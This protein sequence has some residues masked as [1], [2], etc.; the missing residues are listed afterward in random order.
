MTKT[1]KI[2]AALFL[3]AGSVRGAETKTFNIRDFG[4]K[5][6]GKT[7]D[8]A[9]IQKAIDT[10]SA[11]GGGMVLIPEGK[12]VTMPFTLASDIN[13]HLAAGAEILISDDMA[14]YPAEKNRYVDAITAKHAH[15][16][17]ISGTGTINGQGEAWWK[18]FRENPKM[19]HRPYL[20][21][22][23]DCERVKVH[24]VTLCNSPMFHLVP[25]N[26][27]DVTIENIKIKSPSDAPNTDGIDPSGWNFL[28]SSCTI[29][30]G[31]DNIAIKPNPG[32]RVPGDKNFFVKDCTFIHGHGMSVGSGTAGGLDGLTVSNCTFHE[33]DYGIR[34]KSLRG[35]GG[36][37]ENCTYENLTMSAI[38]KAP[39]SIVDYYPERTAPKDPATEK[40][41]AVNDRTPKN[42]NVLVRNVTAT[43]CPNAGIIRGLPEAPIDGITFSNVNLSAKNGMIIYH[44]RNVRFIDSKITVEKGKTLTTFDAD[45]SGIK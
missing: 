32:S 11:A 1:L 26:C 10:A 16:L 17:E 36:M 18:A 19:T 28:I 42:R 27:T 20:I 7:L 12:F 37:L 34:I 3:L 15:D 41:E 43:D 45:V 22:I 31:D 4:A 5:G 24:D 38:K 44:A 39:I 23:S 9:A 30:G 8:T 13:F 29:D 21:K 2:I 25:Q 40:A 6:D 14:H 33:T 35:N